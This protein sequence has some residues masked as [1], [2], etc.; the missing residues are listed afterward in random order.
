MIILA[1]THMLIW[2]LLDDD[3]LVL[4]IELINKNV[5]QKRLFFFDKHYKLIYIH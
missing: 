5:Y 1:D 2:S 3:K 4:Q